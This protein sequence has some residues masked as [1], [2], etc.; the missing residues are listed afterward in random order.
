L[1]VGEVEEIEGLLPEST[2]FVLRPYLG[3]ASA[4]QWAKGLGRDTSAPSS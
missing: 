1:I 3:A 2:E 4:A